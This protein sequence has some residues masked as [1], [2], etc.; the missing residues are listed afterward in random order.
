MTT[1]VTVAIV[2]A[3]GYG[4]TKAIAES[5]AKGA[6][7]VPGT[8]VQSFHLPEIDWDA[9][10]AADAIIFGSPTYMGNVSAEFAKFKDETSKV[11]FNKG[12]ADKIAA[13]FSVSGSYFGDKATTLGSLQTL[14]MQHHMV[15]VGLNL[16]GGYN[17]S[18]GSLEDLNR[19]GSYSGLM[20]QANVDQGNEG[21]APSDF[22]TAEHFGARVA[23]ATHRW[24]A[25]KQ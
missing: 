3:S 7:S 4:H 23:T 11:W 20:V 14:A 17:S 8:T 10:S 6:E 2:F 21:I 1:N 13:G 22:R 9:L 16:H 19:I 18:K 5:V 25:G 12:W 24:V 15:W